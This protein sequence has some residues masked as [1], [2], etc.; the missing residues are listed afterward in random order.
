[1][2]QI[3]TEYCVDPGRVTVEH[4]LRNPGWEARLRRELGEDYEPTPYYHPDKVKFKEVEAKS[5][6]EVAFL[7]DMW[8]DIVDSDLHYKFVMKKKEGRWLVDHKMVWNG[9]WERTPF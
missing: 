7:I 9:R 3:I 4:V 6:S 2:N 8:D 1:M 5:S